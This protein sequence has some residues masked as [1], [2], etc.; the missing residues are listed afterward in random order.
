MRSTRWRTAS[1]STTDRFGQLIGDTGAVY[2][3]PADV[4]SH[5]VITAFIHD[6]FTVYN[7]GPAL[8]RN[9]LEAQS[10]FVDGNSGVVGVLKQY[11]D[12]SSPR[13]SDLK[14]DQSSSHKNVRSR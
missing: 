4:S 6:V 11:W 10:D 3:V 7:S 5:S 12:A 9:Y 8:Q 14:W 2:R 1:R 13:K